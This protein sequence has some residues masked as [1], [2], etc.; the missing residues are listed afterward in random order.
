M[1]QFLYRNTTY[2]RKAFL[3]FTYKHQNWQN[4][5]LKKQII[6]EVKEMAKSQ[7]LAH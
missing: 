1:D 2:A 4:T 7:L 5:V 3:G 6:N